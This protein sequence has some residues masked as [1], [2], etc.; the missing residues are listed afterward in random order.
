MTMLTGRT[1]SC[2]SML[3]DLM[4]CPSAPQSNIEGVRRSAARLVFMTTSGGSAGGLHSGGDLTLT[5]NPACLL[6]WLGISFPQL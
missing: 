5:E 2:L 1:V 4:T 6:G 3:V